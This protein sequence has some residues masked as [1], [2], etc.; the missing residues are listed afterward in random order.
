MQAPPSAR[1]V[2]VS[3]HIPAIGLSVPLST[4]GLNPDGTVEVPTSYQQAGWFGL[5]PTPG[6]RGSAVMLGHVDSHS[7][8]GVFFQLRTLTGGDK[9]AVDLADGSTATFAVIGVVTYAKEQFPAKQVYGS[10]G[11]SALQLVT[12]GGT[13]DTQTGGYLSNVVVYTAL[14]SLTPGTQTPSVAERPV[15]KL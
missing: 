14:V 3:L 15:A 8:P 12:C 4:L 11:Y 13:F 5:G 7:G 10:H 9:V 1:S 2:P 6:Q